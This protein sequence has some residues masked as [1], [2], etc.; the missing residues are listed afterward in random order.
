VIENTVALLDGKPAANVLLYGDAGTGKSSTV[1]A[2]VNEYAERGLRL[3]EVKKEC[4][5]DIPSI[6]QQI[7][8]NPLKFILFIDDLSFEREHDQF[9][10]S[11]RCWKD[12]LRRNR[13]I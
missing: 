10:S 9:N 8:G 7:D 4:L 13:P 12:R 1:K 11:K 6:L 3:I 5:N 2:I